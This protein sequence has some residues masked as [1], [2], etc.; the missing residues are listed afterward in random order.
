MKN[1]IILLIL[2]FSLNSC[3]LD[4]PYVWICKNENWSIFSDGHKSYCVDETNKEIFPAYWFWYD[5]PDFN[6][7]WYS[8]VSFYNSKLYNN[9][10]ESQEKLRIQEE[11]QRQKEKDEEMRKLF[12]KRNKYEQ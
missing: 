9:Y 6:I 2:I 3:F 4:H 10:A 11:N 5:F 7:E 12:D 1:K 8:W